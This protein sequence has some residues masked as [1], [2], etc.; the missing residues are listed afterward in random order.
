MTNK[1]IADAIAKD[2]FTDE[3][4]GKRLVWVNFADD[5]CV[6]R[7]GM[8]EPVAAAQILKVLNKHRPEGREN[9]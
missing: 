4:T 7:F 6:E 9:Q 1:Q 5:D 8:K 3:T 2:L